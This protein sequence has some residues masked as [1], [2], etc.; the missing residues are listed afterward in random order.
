MTPEADPGYGERLLTLTEYRDYML[1]IIFVDYHDTVKNGK[2][3][4]QHFLETAPATSQRLYS[5]EDL[6]LAI[7]KRTPR[8][9]NPDGSVRFGNRFWTVAT[10]ELA[11]FRKL[12]DFINIE[13]LVLTNPAT[14]DTPYLIAWEPPQG[15]VEIIGRAELM[16]GRADSDD[17][18]LLRANSK[19][20]KKRE[21]QR[22]T[23]EKRSML[24]DHLAF[25]KLISEQAQAEY[26]IAPLPPAQHP[27]ARLEAI[28][29]PAEPDADF[30]DPFPEFGREPELEGETIDEMFDNLRRNRL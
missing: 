7:A 26:N 29:G 10:G 25:P 15:G 9:V 8:T 24:N 14:P 22:Q 16:P 13:V 4:L 27:K 18:R 12:V 11:N 6:M 3:R 20:A 30:D 28:S 21:L 2:S 17:A 5:Q 19:A 1:D 23:Q